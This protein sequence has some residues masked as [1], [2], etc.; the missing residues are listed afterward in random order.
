MIQIKPF[1]VNIKMKPFSNK[2]L[3]TFL[4]FRLKFRSG[5]PFFRRF[6][7]LQKKKKTFGK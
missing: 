7:M 6:K 5:K 1:T 4:L 3:P 2:I